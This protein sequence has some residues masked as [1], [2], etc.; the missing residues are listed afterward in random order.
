MFLPGASVVVLLAV[1]LRIV[2]GAVKHVQGEPS[3]ISTTIWVLSELLIP[4]VVQY[5]MH[6]AVQGQ[7]SR[8]EASAVQGAC[9]AGGRMTPP[10][11]AT[12]STKV[13]FEQEQQMGPSTDDVKKAGASSTSLPDKHG[14]HASPSLLEECQSSAGSSQPSA[15]QRTIHAQQGMA[16][17][18]SSMAQPKTERPAW[19]AVAEDEGGRALLPTLAVSHRLSSATVAARVQRVRH[20]QNWGGMLAVLFQ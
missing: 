14:S 13:S 1:H 18:G 3:L 5:Y 6:K 10:S 15:P 20:R 4:H 11:A 16:P 8:T 12:A 7:Y 2:Y 17:D 19:A 9:I